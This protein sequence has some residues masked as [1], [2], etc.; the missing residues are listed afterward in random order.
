MCGQEADKLRRDHFAP[1]HEGED[2]EVAGVS[3]TVR[4]GPHPTRQEPMNKQK[5][6]RIVNPVLF[7]SLAVQAGTGGIIAFRL[8][9]PFTQTVFEA[10]EHN[11]ALL[12]ALAVTHLTLNWGWVKANYLKKF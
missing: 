8:R 7:L 3:S 5:W 2:G 6:L 12:I 10:H 4:P 11:G 9:T 1:P